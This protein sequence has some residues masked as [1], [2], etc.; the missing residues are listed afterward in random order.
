MLTR[1]L[2]FWVLVDEKSTKRKV[3]GKIQ[4]EENLNFQKLTQRV[5]KAF[6]FWLIV[7]FETRDV[8]FIDFDLF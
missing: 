3:A 2:A 5:P 4:L 8:V 6:L 7:E 1:D